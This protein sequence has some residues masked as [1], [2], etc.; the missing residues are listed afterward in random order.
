MLL[1]VV[2]TAIDGQLAEE[3]AR[4]VSGA[5]RVGKQPERGARARRGVII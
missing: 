1:G 2:D 5:L 3:C 4:E